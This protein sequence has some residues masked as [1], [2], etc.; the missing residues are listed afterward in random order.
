MKEKIT[1]EFYENV[2][3]VI[4]QPIKVFKQEF[5]VRKNIV[6]SNCQDN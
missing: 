6:F 5:P 3:I 2:P 4:K 1:K